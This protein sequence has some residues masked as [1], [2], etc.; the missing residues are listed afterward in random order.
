MLLP[1]AILTLN[2]MLCLGQLVLYR[3]DSNKHLHLCQVIIHPVEFPLCGPPPR[4]PQGKHE[5]PVLRKSV[6]F[7]NGD[8]SGGSATS[9]PIP[10]ID[11]DATRELSLT[12]LVSLDRLNRNVL[13]S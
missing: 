1:K 10:S 2:D 12:L 5:V 9:T 3:A 6:G 8:V 13:W 7:Q 11:S 4:I